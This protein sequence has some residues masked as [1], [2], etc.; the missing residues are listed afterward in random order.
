[1]E[2]IAKGIKVAKPKAVAAAQEAFDA[3]KGKM[4]SKRDEIQSTVD[5]LKD[6]FAGI[7][8]SVKGA[9]TGDLFGVEAS[10]GKT[11]GQNFI[12]GLMG[13][14]AELTGLLASFNT[15]KGWGVAPA[16]LTQLFAS[17]NGGLITEL[18]GMG[19]AGALSTASLF[20]EVTNLS[21]Q[22]G[23]AVASNDAVATELATANDTLLRM[24]T[25]L[26]YLGSD[27]GKELNQAA[28]KAQRDKKKR[29]KK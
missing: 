24:E 7:V 4:E 17:G 27:I 3:L 9:F 11:V 18:A 14:K 5:S 20:G 19:Q 1:M 16:F 23:T 22:L 28:S 10:E 12:D 26:S 13:K 25:A 6:A 29:G 8:E 21:T 2:R 15:L